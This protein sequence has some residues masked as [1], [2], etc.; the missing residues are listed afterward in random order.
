MILEA[1]WSSYLEQGHKRSSTSPVEAI[2]AQDCNVIGGDDVTATINYQRWAFCVHFQHQCRW[3]KQPSRITSSRPT[4]GFGCI[5]SYSATYGSLHTSGLP[6]LTE[7]P[8]QFRSLLKWRRCW[9]GDA[10]NRSAACSWDLFP[11]ANVIEIARF[12]P[13]THRFG[14][15]E[16]SLSLSRTEC[17]ASIASSLPCHHSTQESAVQIGRRLHF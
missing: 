15:R 1:K 4:S 5:L 7:P 2:E 11:H 3:S 9:I 10:A 6:L 13:M 16:I 8:N 17:E 12:W 14:D